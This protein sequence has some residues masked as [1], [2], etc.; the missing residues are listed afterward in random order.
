MR[1]MCSE[2]SHRTLTLLEGTLASLGLLTLLHL[3]IRL[4][5]SDVDL[6]IRHRTVY[7]KGRKVKVL[8]QLCGHVKRFGLSTDPLVIAQAKVP[9]L[10]FETTSGTGSIRFDISINAK[11]GPRAAS[12]IARY[13][14]DMPPLRH[15]ILVIKAFLAIREF[16]SPATG[17]LG[18][19]ALTCLVISFL[20]VRSF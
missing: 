14:Y 13:I 8:R 20:Q 3:L 2:A 10:R 17:G 4:T 19:Y 5:I 11:D 15:L 6:V 12:V 18:S 7:D 16:N 1:Y 9:I